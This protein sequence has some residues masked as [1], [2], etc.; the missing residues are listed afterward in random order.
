MSL[1][2][3]ISPLAAQECGIPEVGRNQDKPHCEGDCIKRF[4]GWVALG[5][6]QDKS[7][8][9]PCLCNLKVSLRSC[10]FFMGLR[11]TFLK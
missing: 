4:L 5:R 9:G 6:G 7:S 10:T 11:V 1:T 8:N 3:R 2:A